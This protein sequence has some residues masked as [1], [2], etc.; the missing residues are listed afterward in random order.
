MNV[1]A[2]LGREPN[3]V[4]ALNLPYESMREMSDVA[5]GSS[6]AQYYEAWAYPPAMLYVWWPIARLWN[7]AA[8]PLDER[9]AAQGVFTARPVPPVLSILMKLPNIAAD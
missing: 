9:Y 8:G 4:A 5:R 1:M 6:Q 7:V 2:E 3:P